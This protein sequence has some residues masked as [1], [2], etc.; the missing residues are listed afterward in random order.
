MVLFF[1]S[2]DSGKIKKSS[3]SIKSFFLPKESE[4]IDNEHASKKDI[5]K[6][7]IPQ[8]KSLAVEKIAEVDLIQ[9][10]DSDENGKDAVECQAVE[11]V[12]TMKK[13]EESGNSS[14]K[15]PKPKWS[16]LW[17]VKKSKMD[18]DNDSDSEDF[19][20]LSNNEEESK[21]SA[22]KSKSRKSKDNSCN[23]EKGIELKDDEKKEKEGRKR[24]K[25][26]KVGDVLIENVKNDEVKEQNTIE[27]EDDQGLPKTSKEI[28]VD[29]EEII[30]LSDIHGRKIESKSHTI[31][32]DNQTK[33]VKSAF[34]V[35]MNPTKSH[36]V[37]DNGKSKEPVTIEDISAPTTP[38]QKSKDQIIVDC[39]P[40]QLL[41]E[42]P[43]SGNYFDVLMMKKKQNENNSNS[44]TSPLSLI[45]I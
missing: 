2:P 38:D 29:K 12:A 7:F 22:K 11:S 15:K 21:N 30:D 13:A 45:H 19:V 5:K 6:F 37:D 41:L 10:S 3:P 25:K 36:I 34:D 26:R 8:N 44:K 27:G 40:K 20:E 32:S 31:S 14:S 18:K 23:E 43:E 9:E 28:I 42:S 24:M 4:K 1:Q 17:R 35:L 33:Q 39:S 16:L